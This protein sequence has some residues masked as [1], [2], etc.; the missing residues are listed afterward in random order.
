MHDIG[1]VPHTNLVLHDVEK[2]KKVLHLC[3]HNAF[4]FINT[5]RKTLYP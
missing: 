4:G 1:Y 2:E 3:H 5:A